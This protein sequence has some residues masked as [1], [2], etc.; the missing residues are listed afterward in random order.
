[1]PLLRS[2]SVV[3]LALC[4]L[5][6]GCAHDSAVLQGDA[7]GLPPIG[8]P[9]DLPPSSPSLAV[10]GELPPAT[11]CAESSQVVA[12]TAITPSQ[13]VHHVAMAVSE[14]AIGVGWTTS[15][16]GSWVQK[17]LEGPAFV[18]VLDEGLH[19][20]REVVLPGEG[21]SDIA[22]APVPGGF[23]VAT[24]EG[25][26]TS[27]RRVGSE[28]SLDTRPVR[29]PGGWG[30]HV[31][32][33]ERREALV[34][35]S[36]RIDGKTVV[37]AA[38]LPDIVEPPA[39]DVAL[40]E[41]PVEPRF[42]S[43]VAHDGGFLIS[44]RGNKGV[45]VVRLERDGRITARHQQVGGHTEYPKLA[46]CGR[47]ASMVWADFSSRGAM[48][49]AWLDDQGAL[50]KEPITLGSVP[51]YFDPSPLVCERGPSIVL[52]NRYTGGTGVAKGLDLV[53]VDERG[54]IGETIPVYSGPY[55][56]Y[57]SR[58]AHLD[59]DVVVSWLALQGSIGIARVR[60]PAA[61]DGGTRGPVIAE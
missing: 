17:S 6:G 40:V 14:R 50:T 28:P 21:I 25:E 8:P 48:K 11:T 10:A 44:M 18:Q 34:L 60:P 24:A 31:A 30:I 22:M 51:E 5:A 39:W 3:A 54:T 37:Q 19:P 47:G 61:P 53:A 27:V 12:C 38:L 35:R 20:I 2:S 32:L 7:L 43:A 36:D 52:L 33:G 46:S 9:P 42:G 23:I 41:G 45:E 4:T 56:A 55:G 59:D 16:N 57:D 1:M 15:G 49:Q 13:P 26:E 29:L 58:I